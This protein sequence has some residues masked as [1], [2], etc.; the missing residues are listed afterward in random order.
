MSPLFPSPPLFLPFPV[1]VPDLDVVVPDLAFG[2]P[3]L[4]PPVASWDEPWPLVLGPWE[5]VTE[6]DGGDEEVVDSPEAVE[7]CDEVVLKG[8]KDAADVTDVKTELCTVVEFEAVVNVLVEP[9]ADAEVVV[10]WTTLVCC[11]EATEKKM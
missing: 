2:E 9:C 6:A 7:L 3:D 11:V 10:V 4:D 1:G 8:V 5:L